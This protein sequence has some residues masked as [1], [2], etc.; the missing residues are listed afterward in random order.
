MRK[1][2]IKFKN[3]INIIIRNIFISEMKISFAN[4]SIKNK[5]IRPI[6]INL[7]YTNKIIMRKI[8]ITVGI[9]TLS[10]YFYNNL[11]YFWKIKR[12]KNLNLKIILGWFYIFF[13]FLTFIKYYK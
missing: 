11:R 13:A 9:K 6:W 12:L 8:K 1:L 2:Q 7:I 3:K 10:N 4:L 5:M